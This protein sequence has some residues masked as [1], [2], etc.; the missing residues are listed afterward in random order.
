MLAQIITTF[1]AHANVSGDLKTLMHE[2][3]II[4]RSSVGATGDTGYMYSMAS[5][6]GGRHSVC[7]PGK[8]AKKEDMHCSQGYNSQV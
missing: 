4:G 5:E 8:I 7:A 3:I 6:A 2:L 1:D